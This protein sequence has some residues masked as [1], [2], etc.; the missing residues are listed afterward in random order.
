MRSSCPSVQQ[1][2]FADDATGTSTCSNLKSWWNKLSL[3]GPAFVYHP[4]ASKTYLVDK[5][6]YMTNALELFV[7]TDVHITIQGKRHPGAAIG[8]RTRP[9]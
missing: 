5:Q 9:W 8:S 1:V 6:E 3:C 2:W 4:N 7:D